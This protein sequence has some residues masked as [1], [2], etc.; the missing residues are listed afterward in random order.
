MDVVADARSTIVVHRGRPNLDHPTPVAD[1]GAVFVG[2]NDDA[3][4]AVD[5][6][7]GDLT[8]RFEAGAPVR[9]TPVV[10][11]APV[12]VG[13]GAGRLVALDRTT[14]AEQWSLAA[15]DKVDGSPALAG[16]YVVVGSNDGTL[17]RRSRFLRSTA[18][19]QTMATRSRRVMRVGLRPR[20]PW[21]RGAPRRCPGVSSPRSRTSSPVP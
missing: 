21:E 4:V 14:G 5:A 6:A 19:A 13:T 9:S 8:W 7:T 18:T 10:S 15:G 2:I 12:F 11:G 17:L 3:L 20:R 1:G 16:P